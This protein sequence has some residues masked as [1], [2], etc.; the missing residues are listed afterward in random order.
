MLSIN[1]DAHHKDGYYDMHYGIGVARKGGLTEA[2][3]F[4]ALTLVEME[5][6]L[7]KRSK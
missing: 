2:M 7:A 5:Q 4:N 3:T 1:P 6:Y